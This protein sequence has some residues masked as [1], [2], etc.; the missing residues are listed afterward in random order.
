M[1]E[2]RLFRATRPETTP[3]TLFDGE[4]AGALHPSSA[5]GVSK[6]T[7]NTEPRPAREVAPIWARWRWAIERAMDRPRPLPWIASVWE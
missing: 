7:V 5:S 1:S 4:V 6:G 3:A 2:I